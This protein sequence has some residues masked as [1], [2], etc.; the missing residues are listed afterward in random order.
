VIGI[1]FE[2]DSQCGLANVQFDLDR[3]TQLDALG[4]SN[5][6]L[7]WEYV[8]A[9]FRPQ[10]RLELSCSN[11]DLA[12]DHSP[13]VGDRRGD[14]VDLETLDVIYRHEVK[15]RRTLPE[16]DV[17]GES[18]DHEGILCGYARPMDTSSNRLVASIWLARTIA[19]VSLLQNSRRV[20]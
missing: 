13:A 12:G 6:G 15:W 20:G 18:R 9:V 1:H 11:Y 7:D 10:C 2:I 17:S 5:G 8:G 3:V 19:T 14:G 4:L 16:P